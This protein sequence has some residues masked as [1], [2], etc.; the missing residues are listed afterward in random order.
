M[1]F[2]AF[3]LLKVVVA[4]ISVPN[5]FK[6]VGCLLRDYAFTRVDLSFL[7]HELVELFVSR[8][9]H[10]EGFR[11]WKSCSIQ[12]AHIRCNFPFV[13][14]NR[15]FIRWILGRRKIDRPETSNVVT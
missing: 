13:S 7:L 14:S 4:L 9:F 15:R 10:L 5:D 6:P 1:T 3:V 2:L 11:Y 12:A 8:E